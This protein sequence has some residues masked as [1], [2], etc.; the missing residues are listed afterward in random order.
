MVT[1]NVNNLDEL[2]IGLILEHHSIPYSLEDVPNINVILI[3][4]KQKAWEFIKG[5]RYIREYLDENDEKIVQ[6]RY[7]YELEQIDDGNGNITITNKVIG[8]DILIEYYKLDGSVG[9][10]K[11]LEKE[12]SRK[13]MTE[14]NRIVRQNQI[15]YLMG[16]GNGFREDAENYPEP[17]KSQLI[18]FANLVDAM[19]LRYET[20]ILEYINTGNIAL[21]NTI[22]NES[23]PVFL[24]GLNQIDPE[25]GWT[26]KETILNEIT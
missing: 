15:D 20:E 19:W 25:T 5:K 11:T 18:Q 1:Y 3:G 12:L 22:N 16:A 14:F 7:V 13:Y 10:T 9:L 2:K 17:Q 24:S 4:L 8:F 26:M 23:D 6:F 21:E